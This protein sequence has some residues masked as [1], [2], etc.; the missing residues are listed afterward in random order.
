MEGQERPSKSIVL[1]AAMMGEQERL[2]TG[3][4]GG[5]WSCSGACAGAG[6]GVVVD[7]VFVVEVVVVT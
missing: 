5:G 6:V 1:L 7:V 3:G 2:V 4:E